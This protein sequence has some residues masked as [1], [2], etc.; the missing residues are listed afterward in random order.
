MYRQAGSH[1]LRPMSG[2][3]ASGEMEI[4]HQD[5]ITLSGASQRWNWHGFLA[6]IKSGSRTS[7][8]NLQVASTTVRD[9]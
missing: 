4:V 5:P 8:C 1:R 2:L 7:T 6:P 9:L 3:L